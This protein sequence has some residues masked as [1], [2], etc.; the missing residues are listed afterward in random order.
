MSASEIKV[1]DIAGAPNDEVE[2]IRNLLNRNGV[3]YYETPRANFG[4]SVSAIWVN[5]EEEYKKARAL[6]DDYQKE[7]LIKIRAA[8]A[9]GK[10]DIAWWKRKEI[11]IFIFIVILL[12]W[13]VYAGVWRP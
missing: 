8:S 1:V 13:M 6:I 11:P 9:K 3:R 12:V 2:D 10:K 4:I 7:R 5:N